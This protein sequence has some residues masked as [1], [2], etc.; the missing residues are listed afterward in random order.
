MTPDQ[1]SAVFRAATAAQASGFITAEELKSLKAEN[2]FQFEGRIAEAIQ[3][4]LSR[5]EPMMA[6]LMIKSSGK[7]PS[8]MAAA[9]QLGLLQDVSVEVQDEAA[10]WNPL[11][12]DEQRNQLVAELTKDGNPYQKKVS[13]DENGKPQPAPYS[14]TKIMQLE[15][16]APEVAARLKKE[17]TPPEPAH[18]FTDREAAL[19]SMHGYSLPTNN[20]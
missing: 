18:N 13:Y 5:Q 9:A 8:L 14:L 16:Q 7:A 2:P 12:E 19:L 11:T 6:R 17:A 3:R 4:E 15:M 10:R 20:Q 1:V